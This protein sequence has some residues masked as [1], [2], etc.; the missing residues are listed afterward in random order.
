MEMY[1]AK[2][3]ETGYPFFADNIGLIF[4]KKGCIARLI[5]E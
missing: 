2:D 3:K 1:H 5:E 4:T